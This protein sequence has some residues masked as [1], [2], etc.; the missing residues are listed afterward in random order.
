MSATTATALRDRDRQ[1]QRRS[2]RHDRASKSIR[3]QIDIGGLTDIQA[4]A[5]IREAEIDILVNLNGYFGRHRL[6]VFAQRPAL[7]RS[8]IGLPGTWARPVSIT[9]SPTRSSFRPWHRFYD[10]QSSPCP[11][12]PSQ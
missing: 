9:S 10:E 8:I 1:R 5:K 11:A 3:C 6:D 12:A 4:A 7:C 2:K